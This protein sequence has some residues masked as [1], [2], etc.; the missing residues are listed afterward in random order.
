MPECPCQ[1]MVN[2]AVF[3]KEPHVRKSHEE[4]SKAA[5]ERGEAE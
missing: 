5:S 3:V 2:G 4:A 1:K